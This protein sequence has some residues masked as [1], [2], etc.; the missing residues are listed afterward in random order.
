M[1][2]SLSDHNLKIKLSS[3]I[4]QFIV[5]DGFLFIKHDNNLFKINVRANDKRLRIFHILREPKKLSEITDLLSEFKK[6]DVIDFLKRLH[7]FNLLKLEKAD[8]H[9]NIT[10]EDVTNKKDFLRYHAKK[11]DTR[12]SYH[13]KILLIGHGK[14]AENLFTYLKNN[15]INCNKMT[16][17]LTGETAEKQI[18]DRIDG[19]SSSSSFGSSSVQYDLIVAV[20]DYPN[21]TLF[22]TVNKICIKKKKPWLRVSFD[23][24]YGYLGPFVLPGKSSC[25]NCCE[26]RLVTNSPHYEYQLWRYKEH[27]PKAKLTISEIFV[28]ILSA[29]CSNEI[30]RYLAHQKPLA[31][32]NL[33]V[34]D[35][36]RMAI[37]KHRIIQHPS[38]Y[39]CAYIKKPMYP[40]LQSIT[41]STR[42]AMP[43]ETLKSCGS[44]TDNELLQRLR[45]IVDEKTGI[46][47]KTEKFYDQNTIGIN[48][49]HFYGANGFY[50]LRVR[51]TRYTPALKY[52]G[53]LM[54][55]I[56][57]GSGFSPSQAKIRALMEFVERYSNM[58]PDES[59]F[60]W[61]TYNDV[62]KKSINPIELG[63]YDDK[64]YQKKGFAC[65]RFSPN[66]NIPWV[67][68]Q[69]LY[70][71]KSVLVCADFVYY[72]AVREKPLVIETS[73]G[74]ASHYDIVQAI[75]NGLYEV[76]ERDA[77]LIMWLNRLSMP[78]LELKNLSFGFEE[79]IKLI[80]EF[81]M[82]VK[83]VDLTNDTNIPT[84]MAVCYNSA[85]KY[86]Q[87]VVGAGSHIEPE[88]A[89]QKALFEI[90][91]LLL[92]YLE[93][94]VTEKITDT[95]QIYD[96]MDHAIFYMNPGMRKYWDFMIS[97]KKKSEL[98]SLS[99][100]P[101]ENNHKLL[102]QIVERLHTLNHR[103]IWVNI[104]PSDIE[105][106]DLKVVKVFIT[107]F[108]P[109]YFR[110]DRRL[111]RERLYKVPARL[112]Y[113]DRRERKTLELNPALHP[114]S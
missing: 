104:T 4:S 110:N 40:K 25:Y 32:D 37:S 33:F 52:N 87:L 9:R 92:D 50:P 55:S 114:L 86:P 26:L 21:I 103:V 35:T 97:G 67:E 22:E 64:Q 72:P 20:E 8:A 12:Q 56:G 46:V 94:P 100:R 61:T 54:E 76:I 101:L 2:L 19:A 107:G 98:S 62:K 81:G 109:L 13:P 69:D 75:L 71:G 112:G 18:N 29:M 68:G 93:N 85:D 48:F 53:N 42:N 24:N 47:T 43:G 44:L 27:I 16:S 108:Q 79:S 1:K 102:T 65:S 77:F 63:V 106:M 45:E 78:I 105:R 90:E 84:V 111:S 99:T 15:G 39:C 3:G 51:K 6:K 23:D 31:I 38:C 30:I 95:D 96:P 66:S 60:I 70:S 91:M 59:R 88:K 10:F 113:M 49:H 57:A 36:R 17:V 82:T 73:N 28:D 7:S 11:H 89:V 58:L 5:N 80:N 83:L 41:N 34:L 74:A 14:L